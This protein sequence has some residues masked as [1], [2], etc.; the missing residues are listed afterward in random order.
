MRAVKSLPC[1]GRSSAHDRRVAILNRH[2]NVSLALALALSASPGRGAAQDANVA[3]SDE[4]APAALPPPANEEVPP[5]PPPNEVPILT[6][7]A[8]PEMVERDGVL[9]ERRTQPRTR[10]EEIEAQDA[11]LEAAENALPP[12]PD[13]EFRL[14]VG[15]GIALP[16]SVYEVPFLRIHQDFEWLPSAV[17]P[18]VFG[19]SGAQY[20][21]NATFGSVGGRIGATAFFCE[22][23]GMR[24]QGGIST[25][26]G[27]FIGSN[28]VA[29]E[30]TGEGDVRLLFDALE[31]HLRVGFAGS[32]GINMLFA[33]LGLGVA[34]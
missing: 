15:T 25:Q 5:P 7:E 23:E 12:P 19:V 8:E 14:R 10:E 30:A 24:C 6:E 33:D 16:L 13:P 20:I 28:S 1:V 32:G 11:A 17:A 9:F 18:F 34:F 3:S 4:N 29:F 27:V 2:V 26:I 31:V 21:G 22:V